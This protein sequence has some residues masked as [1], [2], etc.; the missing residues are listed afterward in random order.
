MREE[1]GQGVAEGGEGR[2]GQPGLEAKAGSEAAQLVIVEAEPGGLHLLLPP[3]L[4]PAILEPDLEIVKLF[5]FSF[6]LYSCVKF[7]LKVF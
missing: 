5:N 7:G 6:K 4:G 1:A 3:P 2:G